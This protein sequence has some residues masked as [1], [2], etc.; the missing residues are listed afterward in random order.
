ML[1]RGTEHGD[2]MALYRDSGLEIGKGWIAE[3]NPVLSIAARRGKTLLGA[4]TVS[5][6]FGRLILDYLAVKP[7]ARGL[8]LGKRLTESCLDYAKAAGEPALWVAAREPG[9]YRHL[10]A[11]ETDDTAL[12]ADCRCCPDYM[13]A[14]SPIELVFKLKETQ[15]HSSEK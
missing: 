1:Q 8:G 2:L 12:L 7:E 10:D 6:R 14:C 3:N 11:Q 4:A 13:K 5:R 9:F 15:S